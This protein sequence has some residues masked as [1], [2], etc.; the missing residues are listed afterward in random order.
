VPK[1]QDDRAKSNIPESIASSIANRV[2]K[3]KLLNSG[4]QEDML[5]RPI[6]FVLLMV[7]HWEVAVVAT[8][9]VCWLS[10]SIQVS[11]NLNK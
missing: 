11:T 1:L 5:V 2:N 4:S 9:S 7:N 10:T 3:T 6:P 8:V